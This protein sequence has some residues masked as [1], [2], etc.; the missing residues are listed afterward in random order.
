MSSVLVV[1]G[2]ITGL[3]AAW[4]VAGAGRPVTLVESQPRFG[5]KVHTERIA[6]YLIEHG[7]DSFITYK[8]AA[9]E[10]AR[11]LGLGEQVI[12]VSEP[13]SVNL[14]VSG[15]MRPMPEGMGLVLPT[16]LAPFARTRILSW[17]QKV[18]AAAD[19]VLPRV[20]TEDDM[21]IG[22][23]LRRRLG[24][25][26]VQRFAD[27]LLGGVY[28][29]RVD[30]LSV[31]AVLPMLRT[32]EAEHRSLM[33]ASL[34]QGR[35]AR[36][37]GGPGGSPFRSL[38]DGMGSLVDALCSALGQRGVDLQPGISVL[39]VHPG[40]TGVDVELSSGATMT[41]AAVLLACGAES[42]ARLVAPFAD[43]A[44]AALA[45]VPLGSTTSVSLGFDA[46]SFS[47][48]LVG[49][50]Y[51]EAGPDPAPISGIT[52]S[53]NKWVGRAPEGKVLVRAFVPD[54][55]GPLAAAP[56]EVILAAV[57]QYVAGVLGATSP[58]E[59]QHVVRWTSAMPKYVVGHRTRVARVEAG[60]P[61]RVVI[62]GS[63]LNGVGIP[64]CI[65][66][67]RRVARE[68]VRGIDASGHLRG[69]AHTA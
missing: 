5:G 23:L 49:H 59:L 52:I 6:G 22:E 17:P 1:G 8:P 51:L 16:Q 29:A 45:G 25:G 65:A 4:E 43:D 55:V 21:S 7:P 56:D 31:D 67:G 18:R 57:T 42:A 61:P 64:D 58:P 37:R 9:L 20:L 19:A 62:A 41:V 13:R 63:A 3:S 50:G 15:R 14:R 54:R 44:A 48:P 28:G 34:A 10:L 33:L 38:R 39:A 53:S 32:S 69:P 47:E 2:G 24:D 46:A 68:T 12:G 36:R 40:P 66:D 30:D 35:A 27:P 11:E 60:L 26:V